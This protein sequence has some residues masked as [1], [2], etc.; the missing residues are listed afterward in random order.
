MDDYPD[1]F[2]DGARIV[3]GP[4][5]ITVALTRSHVSPSEDVPA[6]PPE[7]M[8][9]VRLNH[10]MAAQLVGLLAQAIKALQD[11]PQAGLSQS[12]VVEEVQPQEVEGS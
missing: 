10:V 6:M 8:A 9:V 3:Y 5:G 2:A 7:I 11:S 4:P 12:L 1:F